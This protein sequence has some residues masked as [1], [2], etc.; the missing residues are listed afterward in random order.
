MEVDWASIY[1]NRDDY[2]RNQFGRG[3]CLVF[4]SLN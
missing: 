3:Y 4:V 2:K 1:C